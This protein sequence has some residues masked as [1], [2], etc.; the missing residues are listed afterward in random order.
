VQRQDDRIEVLRE[1]FRSYERD[2]IPV[3]EFFRREF[4]NVTAD[5]SAA[6]AP[7]QVFNR[8]WRRL[9]EI[10]TGIAI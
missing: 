7:D 8:V 5:E 1:R 9:A 10:I 6:P 2:T 3:V 4:G